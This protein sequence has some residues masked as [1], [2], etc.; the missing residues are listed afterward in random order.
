[1]LFPRQKQDTCKGHRLLFAS[2]CVAGGQVFGRF[3]VAF[4]VGFHVGVLLARRDKSGFRSV[5]IA[6]EM[7]LQNAAPG[8]HHAECAVVFK[9]LHELS[10]VL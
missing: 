2:L 7:A 5:G 6:C 10:R 8:E 4:Q 1:M 3:A 9:P